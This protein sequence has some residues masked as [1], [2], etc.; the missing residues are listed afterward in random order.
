[1]N[2]FYLRQSGK[3][4]KVPIF[5][6]QYITGEKKF[7]KVYT[8]QRSYVTDI[9]LNSFEKGLPQN[10]FCRIHRSFIISL[11]HLSDFDNNTAFIAGEKIPIAKAYK[12]V[13]HSKIFVFEENGVSNRWIRYNDFSSFF[14][15]GTI[16]WGCLV[17]SRISF[18]LLKLK[19]QP[20]MSA[21]Q[22]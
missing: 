11:L 19:F 18:N 21:T 15:P 10:L 4:T 16:N 5:E 13:L 6:I 7:I 14:G 20:E 3:Y 8:T 17:D 2:F 9:S 22:G 12:Q 1:M